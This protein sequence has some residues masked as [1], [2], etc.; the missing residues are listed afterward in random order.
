MGSSWRKEDASFKFRLGEFNLFKL[1]LKALTLDQHF[2]NMP[3]GIYET[4]PGPG[5]TGRGARVVLIRSCPVDKE[6]PVFSFRSG[7]IR[8]VPSRYRRYYIE[9]SCPFEEYLKKFSSRSRSTLLRKVRRF[10][11][12]CDGKA[13]CREYKDPAEVDEFY[14]YARLISEKTYQDRLLGCG[15]PAGK[16][17]GEELT[18]LAKQDA[19]RGFVLFHKANPVAYL[20]AP[21]EDNILYYR[22]VGYDPGYREHS[23]GTVLQYLALQKLF[24]EKR[25]RMFDFTEGEGRHK[26]FFS[27]NIQRCADVYFFKFG[28]GNAAIVLTHAFFD[29]LSRSIVRV[30]DVF[31]VKSRV[32]KFL[33]SRA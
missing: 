21:V 19:I 11:D 24:S 14:N 17:I 33:R 22:F 30:L 7:H 5:E 8:Y 9:M 16:D 25:F 26:E 2:S 23:P 18:R 32:K 28:F 3:A 13:E 4:P 10:S 20:Y 1:R 15:F 12:Y 29:R 6:L 27:T 31:K